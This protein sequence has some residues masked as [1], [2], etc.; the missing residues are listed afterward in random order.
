[1]NK[2][3][4][5]PRTPTQEMYDAG[6]NAVATR[7]EGST[8]A[9]LAGL[10]WDAMFAVASQQ[11]W[12]KTTERLPTAEDADENC[13]VFYG[14]QD[15]RIVLGYW[16]HAESYARDVGYEYWMAKPNLPWPTP[17]AP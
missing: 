2:F 12:V 8:F 4:V 9:S 16:A 7:P 11:E 6:E 3:G 10:V 14:S 17:P 13:H 5:T 15:G 1:M